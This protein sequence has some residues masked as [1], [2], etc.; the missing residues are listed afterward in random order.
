MPIFRRSTLVLVQSLAATLLAGGAAAHPSL[1]T[2]SRARPADPRCR[3]PDPAERQRIRRRKGRSVVGRQGRSRGLPAVVRGDRQ[4]EPSQERRLPLADR[5]RNEL[6]RDRLDEARRRVRT[7]CRR[8]PGR[9]AKRARHPCTGTARSGSSSTTVATTAASERSGAPPRRPERGTS[10]GSASPI[11]RR[12]APGAWD[13]RFVAD[14]KV[15]PPWEGPDELWRMYY[16]GRDASGRGQVGLA[17]S[18][19]GVSFTKYGGPVVGF[20][21][22]GAWDGSDIQAFT[23]EWDERLGMF[24]GWYVAGSA[25]GAV[26]SPDGVSWSRAAENPVLNSLPGD[27]V[28]DSIDSYLDDGRYRIVYGQYDL[29]ATPPLRGKGEAW[30]AEDV[31]APAPD[32]PAPDPP[33]RPPAP[34]PPAPIRPLRQ[35]RRLL[36]RHALE[37]TAAAIA[38]RASEDDGDVER[39]MRSIR[40]LPMP[41]RSRTPPARR[42]SSAA[43]RRSGLTSQSAWHCC[44]STLPG[45]RTT[46][47]SGRLSCS[48]T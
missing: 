5:L 20:G 41:R 16:I 39:G 14:A 43:R 48:C 13:E 35:L 36:L 7:A 32:P 29:G 15:V 8:L 42:S 2:P 17:T 11:L 19:D 12:G 21:A 44:A 37:A 6:R 26:W 45:S 38:V 4:R 23:P 47:S 1:P 40:R 24:R 25:A 34:D 3:Q 9:T 46:Q 30:V 10:P 33:A 22:S 27:R 28:E 31:A 18:T